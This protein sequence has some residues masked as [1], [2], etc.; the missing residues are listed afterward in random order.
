MVQ[1][2]RR[3]NIDG[4][5]F[6]Y[7]RKQGILFAEKEKLLAPEI[8]LGGNFV[9][10]QNGGFYSTTTVYGYVKKNNV[11]ESYKCLMAILNSK[12]F[13]WYLVN[14]GTV[15][16][17]GYFRYKPNYIKPFPIPSIIPAKSIERLENLVD[18]IIRIKQESISIKLANIENNIDKIVYELYDL[19]QDEIDL[20][21]KC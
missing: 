19:S 2:I 1:N 17:N 21:E 3:F 10:D 8:S 9:Y 6:Q 7:G 5:W 15:L 12:L 4:E 20:I 11:K 16:A 14:T 13:W 18:Q